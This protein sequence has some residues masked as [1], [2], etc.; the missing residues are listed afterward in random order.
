MAL[1]LPADCQANIQEAEALWN[2][3][4]RPGSLLRYEMALESA[5]QVGPAVEGVV[6]VGKGY[7]LLSSAARVEA[8]TG[9]CDA[10]AFAEAERCL[11]QARVSAQGGQAS[12]LDN[13]LA[14]ARAGRERG[15]LQGSV[16][17][18]EHVLAAAGLQKIAREEALLHGGVLADGSVLNEGWMSSD[19]KSQ[20][21]QQC[22]GKGSAKGLG[23][24]VVD[25]AVVELVAME[26]AGQWERI[27]A[28]LPEKI[29]EITAADAEGG[30]QA[31]VEQLTPEDVERRWQEIAPAVKERLSHNP[32]MP[33]GHTC[34]T[35]PT[36]D[37]CHLHTDLED[38]A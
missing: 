28:M 24:G 29:R 23:L 13:L 36:R 31:R 1:V 15:N 17:K 14:Q 2:A 35:C 4:D 6:L 32:E 22:V 7:A 5:R 25:Q 16:G 33:C 34:G 26:G 19:C 3:G 20:K 11:E 18:M 12:F 10:E 27:A 38:L 37:S 9:Q 21:E 8:D 30:V